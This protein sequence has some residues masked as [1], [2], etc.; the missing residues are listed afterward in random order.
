MARTTRSIDGAFAG[1]GAVHQ[2]G[3]SL[4]IY[5]CNTCQHEVVWAESKRT[6]R[7]YLANVH[8]G[9]QGARFYV[10]ASIHK[11][12]DR[13]AFDAAIDEM[14]DVDALRA[15]VI[16]DLEDDAE[17]EYDDYAASE[18]L[19]F[20]REQVRAAYAQR[21]PVAT[22]RG[23]YYD[24]TKYRITTPFPPVLVRSILA[25]GD[26]QSMASYGSFGG[27]STIG[28]VSADAYPNAVI[29]ESVY[30]IGD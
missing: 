24:I 23:A 10:A 26:G 27:Y 4:P 28:S 13:P 3:G 9:Y 12:E 17:A 8:R 25:A 6:G 15:A 19:S 7:K 16:D 29:V 20:A 14:R 1:V 5:T 21:T 18:F 30:H 22:E 2:T 11:C